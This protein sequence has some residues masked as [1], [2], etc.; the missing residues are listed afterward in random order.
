MNSKE[1]E[2]FCDASIRQYLDGRVFG[3][4]G[5]IAPI[6][7]SKSLEVIPDTTNNAAE[8]TAIYLGVKMAKELKNLY[9]DIEEI[10]I[11][12]DSKVSVF[13]LRNWMKDWINNMQDGILYGSNKDTPVA[14]QQI[15]LK[16][17]AFLESNNLKINLKHQKG[18]V[19][20]LNQN[21]LDKARKLYFESNNEFID[22]QT[23]SRISFYNNVVDEE[24]RNFLATVNESQYPPIEKESNLVPMCY[25]VPK[26]QSL[27]YIN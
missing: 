20:A 9:P 18:H 19:N 6:Y 2:I 14:N 22:T 13:G 25:Y 21:K 15:F 4:A 27:Q 23:L 7:K 12:S 26:V 24:T 3:C 5:A 17:I 16:I 11:Y 10:T 1:L 8:I